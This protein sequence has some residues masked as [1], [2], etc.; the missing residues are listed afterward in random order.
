MQNRSV[1]LYRAIRAATLAG[2]LLPLVPADA[3]SMR[4][5]DLAQGKILVA[6]R[7]STD[8]NFMNSVIVLAQYGQS[9]ALGL[10]IQYRSELP[11]RKA[12]S[13]VKGSEMRGDPI[14]IG[15]PVELPVVL[16][17]LR[18]PSPPAGAKPVTARLYLMTSRLSIG[19]AMAAGRPA[20]DFRVFLG[21]SGWGAG[22]LERE[23]RRSGWY[24]FDYDESLVFDAHPETLWDRLIA[25]TGRQL[26]M[27]DGSPGK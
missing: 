2:L 18:G 14:F 19:D 26:A 15:G 21:Y 3:Q 11:I 4:V 16:G 9:G 8:P 24:I 25:R 1:K 23:V 10:M 12:L 5:E 13:S 27:L 22:Q 7:E 6:P 20:S 17:L